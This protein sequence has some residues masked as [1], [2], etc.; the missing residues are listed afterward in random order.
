MPQVGAFPQHQP[1]IGSQAPGRLAIT[2]IN[3]INAAGTV[4]QRQSVKPPVEMPPSRQTRSLTSIGNASRPASNF[5]PHGRQTGAAARPAGPAPDAPPYR[6]YRAG[7]GAIHTLPA[8]INCWAC[9]RDVTSPRVS[10]SRSSRCFDAIHNSQRRS[11]FNSV[12]IREPSEGR[13]SSSSGVST[14]ASQL[15][16]N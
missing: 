3:A 6:V 11:A 4:L 2:H 16:G 7:A 15:N 8:R 13:R 12:A 1:F 5:S 9:W 10:S 14:N